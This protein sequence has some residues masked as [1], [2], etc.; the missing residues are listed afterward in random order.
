MGIA[1][2]GAYKNQQVRGGRMKVVVMK[3]TF[4]C[5]KITV[6]CQDVPTAF[7]LGFRLMDNVRRQCDA[8]WPGLGAPPSESRCTL[9]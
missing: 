6:F 1:G 9:P 8:P 3:C 7:L 4:L 2:L 5:R